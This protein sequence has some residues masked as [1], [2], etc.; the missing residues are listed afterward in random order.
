[1]NI[2]T[3]VRILMFGSRVTFEVSVSVTTITGF[4]LLSDL[5]KEIDYI[6]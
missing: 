1:M 6:I 5:P 2:Y 3:N 4:F